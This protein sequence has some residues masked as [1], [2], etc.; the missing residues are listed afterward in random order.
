M[1]AL[2][3]AL[4][5]GLGLIALQAIVSRGGSGRVGQ[6]FAGLQSVIN[7]ALDPTVPAV[8]DRRTTTS[9][10]TVTPSSFTGPSLPAPVSA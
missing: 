10:P 1:R 3:S 5:A 7:R 4:T 9:T 6:A 2:T 8:P